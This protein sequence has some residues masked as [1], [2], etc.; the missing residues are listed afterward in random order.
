[1]SKSNPSD[2]AGSFRVCQEWGQIGPS[3]FVI[4]GIYTKKSLKSVIKY[5]YMKIYK[6]AARHLAGLSSISLDDDELTSLTDDLQKIADSIDELSQLDT[7]GVE[8]TY[9]VIELANV[10]RDDKI[11]PQI[12]REELLAL[13]PEQVNGAIKVPKVL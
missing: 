11:E 13:A 3:H 5:L 8:P 12:P 10:W 6:S 7:T 2:R 1:M 4:W 9:Q